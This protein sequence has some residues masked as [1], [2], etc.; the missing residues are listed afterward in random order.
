MSCVLTRSRM[1]KSTGA[2]ETINRFI[3]AY[4]ILAK[5]VRLLDL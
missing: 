3:E 4:T 5:V 2:N 1:D